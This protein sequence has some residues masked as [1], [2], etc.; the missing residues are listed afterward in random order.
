MQNVLLYQFLLSS[1]KIQLLHLMLQNIPSLLSIRLVFLQFLI[2]RFNICL[3]TFSSIL[4][5]FRNLPSILFICFSGILSLLISTSLLNLLSL[6]IRVWLLGLLGL[7]CV[8]ASILSRVKNLLNLPWF[9]LLVLVRD[10][11]LRSLILLN[12]VLLLSCCLHNYQP[13]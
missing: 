3:S 5:P 9:I 10:L 12:I 7:L 1:R 6:I 2:L 13:I 4:H 8:L 11:L